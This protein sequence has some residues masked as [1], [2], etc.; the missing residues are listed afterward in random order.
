MARTVTGSALAIVVAVA[1]C[2]LV[3]PSSQPAVGPGP[4][5]D[6]VAHGLA[7][8]TNR[9]DLPAGVPST[10]ILD[11]RDPNVPHGLVVRTMDDGREV[12]RGEVV[13]GPGSIRYLL[14]GLVPGGYDFFCP[15]HPIMAGQV[16]V[17]AG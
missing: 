13:L 9:L 6:L 7:F 8:A 11:N 4:V 15:V 12:F 14:P 1:G 2:N 5:E 17:R 16:F 3:Q 10:I